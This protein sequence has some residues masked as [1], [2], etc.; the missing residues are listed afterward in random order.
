MCLLL[1]LVV[2]PVAYSLFDDAKNSS[3]WN[4]LTERLGGAIDGTRQKVAAAASSLF[5]VLGK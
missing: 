1:T 5:G 2:T 3:V 4:W